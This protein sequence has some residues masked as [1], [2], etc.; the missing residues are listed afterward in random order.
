MILPKVR[1]P[2]LVTIRRGGTLTDADHRLLALWAAV[3]A[4]HV[5]PF[6]DAARPDDPRP[7]Q[8]IAQI[9]AW[10][11]GEVSMM[12]TRAAGGHAMAAARD[13]HGAARHAAFAAGQAAAVAHVAAHEL[14]A[15]A[16][17]IKAARDGAPEGEGDAEGRRECRWQRDQLPAA[18]RDLVLDDQRLR[19]ALCW[20][21][22]EC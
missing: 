20:G 7:R 17:A 9:R 6:F 21:V 12:E 15:A 18:I 1:D 14:G 22:F 3:C 2:R 16:Y 11:R 19:N 10:V 13:L 5:L 4:E 8:A